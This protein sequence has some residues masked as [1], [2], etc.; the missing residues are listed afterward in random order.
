M[1]Q[2]NLS[3]C[4]DLALTTPLPRM[5][6]ANA[7]WCQVNLLWCCFKAVAFVV[8]SSEPGGEQGCLHRGLPTLTTSRYRVQKKKSTLWVMESLKQML[9]SSTCRI[10]RRILNFCCRLR[11]QFKRKE[12]LAAQPVSGCF[13]AGEALF[14][15]HLM[16]VSCVPGGASGDRA[17]EDLLEVLSLP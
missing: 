7:N 9:F 14:S 1:P 3:G 4:D 6:S 2:N 8:P 15:P 16:H 11:L 17:L 12:C 5:L 10:H 13:L